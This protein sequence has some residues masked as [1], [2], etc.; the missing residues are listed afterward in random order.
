M[1]ILTILLLVS[2][3]ALGGCATTPL[4]PPPS[5]DEIVQMS[6]DKVPPEDIIRRM[7]EARAVYI[8]SGSELADL[9]A[10]GVPDRVLDYMY[11]ARIAAERDYEYLRARQNAF[12]YGWPYG[13]APYGPWG[14]Y[15][16]WGWGL[17]WHGH[18][19]HHHH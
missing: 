17:R 12:L 6:K 5:I 3:A 13:Y 8:L 16:S 10:R 18:R 19:H 7:R 4:P 9:K 1:R 14:P 11:E 15:S 2:L